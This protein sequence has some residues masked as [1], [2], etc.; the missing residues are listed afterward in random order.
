MTKQEHGGQ[1]VLQVE[2]H[3]QIFFFLRIAAH[4]YPVMVS[5]VFPPQQLIEMFLYILWT[6]AVFVLW[7]IKLLIQS[8]TRMME[9]YFVIALNYIPKV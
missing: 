5:A 1:T 6:A 3:R 4:C 8:Q 2:E 7:L 9:M